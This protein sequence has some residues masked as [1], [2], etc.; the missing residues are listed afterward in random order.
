[1]KIG[2]FYGNQF[3]W[4]TGVVKEAEGGK[5]RVR[6]FGIHPFEV[7]GM[8]DG[9]AY[10]AVSNGDL[11]YATLVY[12]INASSTEH[13]LQLEDWVFGFFADGES[14][15]QPVVVGKLARSD[16]NSGGTF[17]GSGNNGSGTGGGGGNS[18][19]S[20]PSTPGNAY[21]SSGSGP[22]ASMNTENYYGY[23]PGDSNPQKAFNLYTTFLNQEMGVPLDRAKQQAAGIIAS[24]AG[25]SG[26]NIDPDPPGY[27]DGGAAHGIAQWNDRRKFLDQ[28]CQRG[29]LECQLNFSISEL[30][31][32]NF[33]HGHEGKEIGALNDLLSKSNAYDAAYSWTVFYE[34][35]ADKFSK[36]TQRAKSANNYY[37]KLAPN[38]QP[39]R[40]G[41]SSSTTPA[42]E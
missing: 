23:I 31:N 21:K 1:V 10:T 42:R 25:E 24:L 27:N 22:N 18:D 14:C 7:D 15:Q 33:G 39:A 20:G 26:P 8:G 28:M 5:V 38:F 6:C 13:L 37:N 34:R 9:P 16:G 40:I 11:P 4:F 3:K 32:R 12:P 17:L 36:A 2:D 35:P 41:I 29:D 30:K 19:S